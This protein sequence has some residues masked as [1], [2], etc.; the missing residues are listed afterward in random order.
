MEVQHPFFGVVKDALC[1]SAGFMGMD[2]KTLARSIELKSCFLA[3][4]SRL[5]VTDPMYLCIEG[6]SVEGPSPNSFA[7]MLLVYWH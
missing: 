7:D 3:R 1:L 4:P 6:S 2:R 5:A